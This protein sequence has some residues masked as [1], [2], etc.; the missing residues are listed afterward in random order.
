MEFIQLVHAEFQRRLAAHNDWKTKQ[1]HPVIQQTTV[2]AAAAATQT[3]PELPDTPTPSSSDPQEEPIFD[4][5]SSVMP[6]A[7]KTQ[8]GIL[9]QSHAITEELQTKGVTLRKVNVEVKD[10]T[11]KHTKASTSRTSNDLQSWIEKPVD[12]HLETDQ[13]HAGK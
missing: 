4:T 11:V 13:D 9:L 12:Q 7:S 2:P 6:R 3:L 1:D 10:Q 8:S 5:L